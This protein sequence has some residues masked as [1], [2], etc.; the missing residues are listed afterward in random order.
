MCK[1]LLIGLTNINKEIEI[2]YLFIKEN[3]WISKWT[4]KGAWVGVSVAS[5]HIKRGR[6]GGT[7]SWAPPPLGLPTPPL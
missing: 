5:T 2:F 3:L 7:M 4:I 6:G 1:R